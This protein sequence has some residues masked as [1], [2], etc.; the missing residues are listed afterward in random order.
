MTALVVLSWL[1]WVPEGPQ[2]PASPASVPAPAEVVASLESVLAEAIAKAESSVVAIHRD[3]GENPQETEAVRGRKRRR[4]AVD[5][6]RFQARF[7]LPM[8]METEDFISFDYGSGVVVGTQGQILTAFH[9]V[10]GA[11]RLRVRAA[12]QP[13]F[14]AEVIAADPRSD[15]AVI[16]PQPEPGVDPPQLKPLPIG[17]AGRLRKGS[18]LIVLGNPFNAARDG[19]ASAGLG[20]LSN[21]ARRL[22]REPGPDQPQLPNYPTLL[23]LDAKLNLGMSGGAVINLRG[24]LV[25]I[26]TTAASPEGFD[27]QAGYAIPM[28]KLGRRAVETLKEGKE[29]EYGLLG[30][31]PAGHHSNRVDQVYRHSPADLGKLQA[32]DEI[33]AVNDDPVTDFD[34]LI[35]AVNAHAAGEPVRLKIRRGDKVVE[36]T[37]VLAKFP[38]DGEVIATNRSQAWR[39]LRVDYTTAVR[40]PAIA[41]HFLDRTPAGVVVTEVE[42]G[43]PA[44]AAGLKK[45]QLIWRAGERPVPNPQAF[46]QV[47]ADLEDRPV[48]LE[49][50]LGPVTVNSK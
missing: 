20:I 1:A 33:I 2:A 46:A 30:I 44:A 25:G 31:A 49:T 7:G 32:N 15:L 29:V 37:L 11:A 9:V 47:V 39:G 16:A 5:P 42:E 50:D 3:K 8:P 26:T 45:G 18:F 17:D 34:S 10:R 24:E 48:L 4:P 41:P 35:L 12:G 14:D 19:N 36:V 21:R 22:E 43:S 28:D 13:P 27:A 6:S 40:A 23:Q 38:V